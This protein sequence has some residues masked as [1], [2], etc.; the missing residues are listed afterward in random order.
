MAWRGGRMGEILLRCLDAAVTA[1]AHARREGARPLR[2]LLRGS[3]AFDRIPAA[4]NLADTLAPGLAAAVSRRLTDL[5]PLALAASAIEFLDFGSGGTVF[6]LETPAGARALKVFRRSLG[7]P[8]AEQLDF[9]AFYAARYRTVATWYAGVAGLVVPSAFGILPGPILGRPVLAAVQPFLAG[10]KRCFFT[11]LDA[12]AA[13]ERLQGDDTLAEQFRGFA[14][15]TLECWRNGGR[16][17]DLVG[18]EN[19]M[20]VESEGRERLTI[21]D[22]GVFDLADL[23]REAPERHA[24]LGERIASLESLLARLGAS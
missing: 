16:I 3:R 10:R 23:R 22:C 14:R 9:A 17:F 18:R 5:R 8:L 7:R 11:D 2:T 24:A 6:R 20:L 12:A 4:L 15:A 19:L 13:L 21:V 1:P